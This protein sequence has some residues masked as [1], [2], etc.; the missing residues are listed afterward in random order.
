MYIFPQRVAQL[1]GILKLI[2]STQPPLAWQVVV[3]IFLELVN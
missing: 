3:Q 1:K 2:W